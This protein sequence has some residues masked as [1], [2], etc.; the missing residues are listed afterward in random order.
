MTQFKLDL[1]IHTERS[2]D[3]RMTLTQAAAAAKQRGVDA[4]A[5]CD[6]NR[7]VSGDVFAHP[8]RDGVLLI[9]GVEYSTESGHL[10][11]LFLQRP[12]I[13]PG[14]DRKSTRLNSSHVRTSRMPSSA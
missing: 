13:C 3:S 2:P 12:C 9:P 8:V 14:E 1:H 10:L 7:C 4:L 6:H 5:V 11:G